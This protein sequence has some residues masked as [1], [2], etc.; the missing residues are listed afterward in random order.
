MLWSFLQRAAVSPQLTLRS[1]LFLLWDARTLLPSPLIWH[2]M[3][4]EVLRTWRVKFE[5]WC[6]K[7]NKPKKKAKMV[8]FMVSRKQV[9]C[10][11]VCAPQLCSH[12]FYVHCSR[13]CLHFNFSQINLCCRFEDLVSNSVI[14]Y[15]NVKTDQF[16]YFTAL[17]T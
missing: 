15:L 11:G 2:M 6:V 14:T 9:L 17:E 5:P 7:K 12:R 10:C 3:N 8:D 1:H 13:S 4:P 16:R